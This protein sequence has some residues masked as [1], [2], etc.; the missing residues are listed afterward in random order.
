MRLRSVQFF[1]GLIKLVHKHESVQHFKQGHRVWCN[2]QGYAGR[3]GTFA[4]LA[5]GTFKTPIAAVLPLDRSAEVHE[6][7]EADK[8]FGKVIVQV[9][10]GS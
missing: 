1:V 10:D 6:L 4:E 9:E 7:V 3:Q 8:V 5:R 2:N